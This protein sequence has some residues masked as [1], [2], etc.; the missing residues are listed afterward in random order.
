MLPLVSLRRG[1]LGAALVV[2][3][4]LLG[5]LDSWTS[6]GAFGQRRFVGSSALFIVGLAAA[7]TFATGVV[8]QRLVYA[9]VA[10]TVWWNLALIAEFATGLMNRQRLELRRNAYDAFVTVPAMA[11]KLDYRYLFDRSSFYQAPQ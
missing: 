3:I 9:V 7:L 8:R 4:Y 5:S 1:L 11:P 2:Q 6:A 10:V